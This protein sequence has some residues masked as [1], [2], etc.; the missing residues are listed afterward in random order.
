MVGLTSTRLCAAA[1]VMTKTYLRCIFWKT[2]LGME[3]LY[4]VRLSVSFCVVPVYTYIRPLRTRTCAWQCCH[5]LSD[6]DTL[7]TCYSRS[8][9]WLDGS[10]YYCVH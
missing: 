6:D 8:L 4:A 3:L 2:L 10:Y 7:H 5:L 9:L 1:A